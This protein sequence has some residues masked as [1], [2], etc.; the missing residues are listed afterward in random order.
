MNAVDINLSSGH[1]TGSRE[2]DHSLAKAQPSNG[3]CTFS[4]IAPPHICSRFCFGNVPAHLIE[5]ELEAGGGRGGCR[6]LPHRHPGRHASE[7]KGQNVYLLTDLTVTKCS[8]KNRSEFGSRRTNMG[9]LGGTQNFTYFF[10][11]SI[12]ILSQLGHQ[13]DH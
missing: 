8:A 6:H 1:W 4:A 5:W 11:R 2:C 12:V 7:A 10:D 13:A 9:F 3:A